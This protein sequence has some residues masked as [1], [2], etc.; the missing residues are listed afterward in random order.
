[1]T[2]KKRTLLVAW[3]K[4]KQWDRLKEIV[5]DSE[6]LGEAHKDWKKQ[7][8]KNISMFRSSGGIV[9]KMSVDTEKMLAWSNENNIKLDST[10]ISSYAKHLYEE[11][12]PTMVVCWYKKEQWDHLKE[13]ISDPEALSDSYEEWEKTAEKNIDI[14]RSEGQRVK[15]I[16]VDTE[17]M[18]AWAEEN[19]FKLESENLSFYA[20]HLFGNTR[21]NKD[22]KKSSN[23]YGNDFYRQ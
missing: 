12:S 21:L 2:E 10:T 3:F 13:I 7:A 4:E 23:K 19:D 15:K 17:Q 8:E 16:P 9:K 18:L 5:S 22:H 14:F 11:K 6:N 20:M 1:M